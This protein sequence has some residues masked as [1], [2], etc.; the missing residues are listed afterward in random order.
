MQE[1]QTWM[2]TARRNLL[3]VGKTS[4]EYRWSRGRVRPVAKPDTNSERR[5]ST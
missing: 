1:E 4:A 2:A 3:L 5:W